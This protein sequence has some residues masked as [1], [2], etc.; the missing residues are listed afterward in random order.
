MLTFPGKA[1]GGYDAVFGVNRAVAL[2]ACDYWV[3]LDMIYHL[4]HHAGEPPI[5]E[6]EIITNRSNWRATTRRWPHLLTRKWY[7]VRDMDYIDSE[8]RYRIFSCTTAPVAAAH[9]GFTELD[10]YGV[11]WKGSADCDGHCYPTHNRTAQRWADEA[12]V[13]AY[14]TRALANRGVTLRRVGYDALTEAA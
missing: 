7:D 11:D 3:H 5:G 12:K 13:W 14:V 8:V 9:L 6:P 4:L 1:E 10:A 2:R